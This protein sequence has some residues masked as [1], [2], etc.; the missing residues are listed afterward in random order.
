LLFSW[1]VC[2]IIKDFFNQGN[3]ARIISMMF[4]PS[5]G[6]IQERRLW[7]SSLPDTG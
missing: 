7:N 6:N 5:I 4:S 1:D 3:K 2:W